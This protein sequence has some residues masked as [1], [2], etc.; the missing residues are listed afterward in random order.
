MLDVD[1]RVQGL[2]DFASP[3]IRRA[4]TRNPVTGDI[5]SN[6]RITTC[7]QSTLDY[8][9][10]SWCLFKSDQTPPR[11]PVALLILY[12][13][14][15]IVALS[16]HSSTK[17]PHVK[18]KRISTFTRYLLYTR[19]VYHTGRSCP[20]SSRHLSPPPQSTTNCPSHTP[21][22]PGTHRSSN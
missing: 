4:S 17:Y 1:N 18:E 12:T 14:R 7:S 20:I 5:I 6:E 11:V 19:T 9:N 2:G 16:N 22:R 3:Q 13:P 21:K 8:N 10:C 15:I